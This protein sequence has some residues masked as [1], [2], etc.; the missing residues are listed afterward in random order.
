MLPALHS[1]YP[2]VET[3][4]GYWRNGGVIGLVAIVDLLYRSKS[5]VCAAP[6]ILCEAPHVQH[7]LGAMKRVCTAAGVPIAYYKYVRETPG[8]LSARWHDN[9]PRATSASPASG[10]R[11]HM[12]PCNL[13]VT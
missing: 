1:K 13:T 3:M 5:S 6:E 10:I 11:A 12:E 7:M 8:G 9:R 4:V 2:L